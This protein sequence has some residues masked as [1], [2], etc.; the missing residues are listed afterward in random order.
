MNLGISGLKG[1]LEQLAAYLRRSKPHSTPAVVHLQEARL[2]AFEVGRWR[3][4]V[5]GVLPEFSMYAHCKHKGLRT[6]TATVTLVRKELVKWVSPLSVKSPDAV[7][8]D[9]LVALKYAPPNVPCPIVFANVWMPHSGY[10]VHELEAAHKAFGDMVLTWKQQK[11]SVVAVG[12]WNAAICP[13]H[14][15][16]PTVTTDPLTTPGVQHPGA[17]ATTPGTRA[18]DKAFRDMMSRTALQ[19]ITDDVTPTWESSTGTVQAHIDH[20]LC[21]DC[22]IIFRSD[23]VHEVTSSDHSALWVVLQRDVGCWN[24]GQHKRIVTRPC[25]DFS[26]LDNLAP[27]F[28]RKLTEVQGECVDLESL[29]KAMWASGVNVCGLKQGNT[30]RKQFLNNR[31]LKLKQA[32]RAARTL[33][34]V[35]NRGVVCEHKV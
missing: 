30:G 13:E 23:V 3:K 1:S 17:L 24:A 25:L 9:R 19:K 5:S 16:P 35:Y 20:A 2:R 8:S 10:R 33:L 14:R 12:D 27:E 31:V 29:E 18:A 32:I 21:T 11:Y 22:S 15:P 28:Q 26:E 6:T 34:Y 7:L 4:R